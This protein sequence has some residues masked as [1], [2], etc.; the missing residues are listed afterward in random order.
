M[1]VNRGPVDTRPL[2]RRAVRALSPTLIRE[3]IADPL[4]TNSLFLFANTVLGALLGFVYWLVVARLFPVSAV[5]V[6]TAVISAA[7]LLAGLS[8]MGLG[9]SVIRFLWSL[10]TSQGH[11]VI[12]GTLTLGALLG[13]LMSAIYLAGLQ[14]WSP[15][16]VFLRQEVG[17]TL[18]FVV[19]VI[20]W[21]IAPIV[22]QILL[23]HRSASSVFGRNVVMHGAKLALPLFLAPLGGAIAV[24]ASFAVGVGVSSLVALT[25]LRS[26]LRPT[27][28]FRVE[29]RTI[30]RQRH[31]LGYA[32]GNHLGDYLQY[33]PMYIIPLMVL[34]KFGQADTARYHI[35]FMLASMLYAITM[36]LATTAF[37][38]DSAGEQPTPALLRSVRMSAAVLVPGMI[39]LATIGPFVLSLFGEQYAAATGLLRG[40]ALAAPVHAAATLLVAHWRVKR[41]IRRINVFGLCIAAGVVTAVGLAPSLTA[42]GYAYMAGLLPGVLYGL[43]TLQVD[44]KRG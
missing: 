9:L 3:R 8:S 5:G 38:E 22:D 34:A 40:L 32:I 29:L 37:V 28:R 27:Y 6:G 17:W 14:L 7:T 43:A 41:A 11:A 42:V 2:L 39:A 24:Y 21:T 26:R 13:A 10:D 31:I 4:Y 20:A 19:G 1:T 23:A 15:E 36:A 33:A 18:I 16:L 30:S 25:I 12:N 44:A 35:G